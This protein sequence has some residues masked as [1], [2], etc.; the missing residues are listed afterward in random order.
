[1]NYLESAKKPIPV[2]LALGILGGAALIITTIVTSKG[3]AIFIP[4]TVLIIA[5]FSAL[6]A[7][8]WSSFSKRFTTSFLTF[9]VATIIMYL[10]IGFFDA[11]TI[12]EIPVWGHIWRLGLLA[13]IGGV[14]SFAV[15]YLSDVGKAI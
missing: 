1:M 13:A 7:V 14:L 9:M 12:L 3:L 4:Y 15:A 11:G 5:T 6:R 10:F 8:H 2:A